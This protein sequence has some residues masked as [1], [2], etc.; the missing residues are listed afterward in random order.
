ML[1]LKNMEA[2]VNPNINAHKKTC[3]L[4]LDIC[5]TEILPD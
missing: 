2:C 4:P 5:D 1:H 3:R